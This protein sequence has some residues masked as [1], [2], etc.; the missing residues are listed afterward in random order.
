ME[1]PAPSGP[2]PNK[3]RCLTTFLV[4]D[5]EHPDYTVSV[6]PQTVLAPKDRW[7]AY[8]SSGTGTR[9]Y[10]TTFAFGTPCEIPF[11]DTCELFV[12]ESCGVSTETASEPIYSP[13]NDKA[14]YEYPD[15]W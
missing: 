7:S 9:S 5:R 4:S 1:G 3:K 2:I 8:G 12:F 13:S 15:V 14:Y 6:Y 10:V 11:D